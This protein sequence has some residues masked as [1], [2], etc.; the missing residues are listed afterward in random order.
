MSDISEEQMSELLA[1]MNKSAG[2]LGTIADKYGDNTTGRNQARNTLTSDIRTA[3]QADARATRD[4]KSAVEGA[5]DAVKQMGT[6]F[7]SF[8]APT[9]I[10]DSVRR[11]AGELTRTYK[12]LSNYGQSFSGNILKMGQQAAAAGLPL[13]EFANAIKHNSVVVNQMGTQNFFKLAKNVRMLTERSGNYGMTLEQLT[14]MQGDYMDAQRLAGKNLTQM[15]SPATARELQRFALNVS[16]VSDALGANREKVMQM[17]FDIMK[18]EN[19]TSQARL[20]NIKGMGQY[21]DAMQEAVSALAAQPGKAG[22]MLSKGL[23][24]T[25]GSI[26]GALFTDLGKQFVDAGQ[27]QGL[28]L[29]DEANRRIQAG[30][31]S[32]Q[33]SMDLVSNLKRM[34]DNPETLESLRLQAQTGNEA[35]KQILGMTAELKEYSQADIDRAKKE[36]QNTSLLTSFMSSFDSIWKRMKGALI[37]GFLKPF[38]D[39]MGKLDPAKVE[40]FWKGIEDMI[41]TLMMFGE[42]MGEL[43]KAFV[44]KDSLDT[45]LDTVSTVA[46]VGMGIAKFVGDV[47]G[48][49]TSVFNFVHKSLS[50]FGQKTAAVGTGLAALAAWFGGKILIKSL[51]NMI[52]N[53]ISAP[54]VN[55]RGGVVNVRGGGRGGSG[56]M[57]DLF[58]GEDG[59]KGKSGGRGQSRGARMRA[60][61]RRAMGRAMG[62][63]PVGKL[64]GA[65]GGFASK[66][67]GAGKIGGM[68]EGIMGWGGKI[69]PALGKAG[70]VLGPVGV[71]LGAAF[72]LADA[73]Q[74]VK[75][76]HEQIASGKMTP[77]EG[78]KALGKIYGGASGTLAGGAVGALIGQALI[79]IP[80]VGA[81][82]GA[83]V[84]SWAGGKLGEMAGGSAAKM[85]PM[86]KGPAGTAAP[87][88]GPAAAP[89]PA[90]PR[91]FDE[92]KL[93]QIRTDAMLGDK[94][95]LEQL[96]KI[97][98]MIDK[99]T[100]VL[101][102]HSAMNTDAVRNT[103]SILAETRGY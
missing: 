102:Q 3:Q 39:G 70:R 85:F 76:I 7:A 75:A 23:G 2:A 99:Q 13:D 41:P 51:M 57:E 94:N 65:V 55:V 97:T 25:F 12:D 98:D 36:R 27:S 63:S 29:L 33:V 18:Q 64:A 26:N 91:K 93:A 58:D 62:R 86:P 83:G 95:A 84:G 88:G 96:K 72:T 20:N 34:L 80:G 31:D 59:K 54:L 9:V 67:P 24:D 50:I 15:S 21:N 40:Q 66:I 78:R 10:I 38:T 8:L 49:I 32:Q 14:D 53:A 11:Y 101:A 42:R 35:A 68:A 77:E 60:V 100:V 87:A 82:I 79:P 47:I 103:G 81:L 6:R 74:G 28:A 44:N 48:G 16:S 17:T 56:G 46:T 73:V 1:A 52:S 19:V 37:E 43:V 45:L 69:A 71:A 61:Q 89:R 22:E 5:T 92:N 90:Q 4:H 30:E